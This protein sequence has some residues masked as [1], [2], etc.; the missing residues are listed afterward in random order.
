[1][2]GIGPPSDIAWVRRS[3]LPP[4]RHVPPSR[5]RGARQPKASPQ[6]QQ[7]PRAHVQGPE[8]AGGVAS[9][10]LEP[11]V[12]DSTRAVREGS[13]DYRNVRERSSDERVPADADGRPFPGAH[14]A[15][16]P[17]ADAATLTA[18]DPASPPTAHPASLPP[19]EPIR[20]RL[21]DPYPAIPRLRRL[22]DP[23]RGWFRRIERDL[24]H[25][26]SVHFYPS[27]PGIS[28][29]Y[30]AQVDRHLAVSEADIEIA[31]LERPFDGLRILLISDLHAGPFLSPRAMHNALSRLL[32]LRPDLILLGGDLT[33]S[34]VSEILPYRAALRALFAPLGTFAVLGNHDHYTGHPE[35]FAGHLESCGIHLLDNASVVLKRDGA[36]LVLAG[37]DDLYQGR[38]DLAAA[39]RD[40]RT[41]LE[42]LGSG[43][44]QPPVILLSHN[45]DALFEASR[46]GVA[47]VLSG[48]THGGQIRI[49]GLPV[50]VRQSRYRL[51][52]GRYRVD[53][54]ELV[55][56][57]G[58]GASGLPLRLA[59]SPE[60]VLL[61]LRS[62]PR[63]EV[64]TETRPTPQ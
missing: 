12:A 48:H 29:P 42:A 59:C 54:T 20:G 24:S 45:P 44:R 63:P 55:V 28:I 3:S 64:E 40:A 49:P 53:N 47:L 30:S 33:T 8:E 15:S 9:A 22:F 18:S 7:V 58:L 39:L 16:A 57:R 21:H 1:M 27:L 32:S 23:R 36:M 56:S 62:R 5:E 60:A 51:D 37:I 10:T 50:L 25:F 34:R 31:G 13:Q 11:G 17:G 2:A 35:Q 41:K 6:T 43:A 26:L 46:Q 19:P 4:P 52:E 38:P 14:H 61:Q